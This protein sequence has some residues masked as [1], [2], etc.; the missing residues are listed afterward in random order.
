MGFEG[1]FPL[2]G[3]LRVGEIAPR[4]RTTARRGSRLAAR[5]K[6]LTPRPMEAAMQKLILS[7]PRFLVTGLMLVVGTA[8]APLTPTSDLLP[9]TAWGQDPETAAVPGQELDTHHLEL[10]GGTDSPE[11][12]RCPQI[13]VAIPASA[14]VAPAAIG[15]AGCWRALILAGRAFLECIE[16][17]AAIAD[18][19]VVNV[20]LCLNC[21]WNKIKDEPD[22]RECWEQIRDWVARRL[23]TDPGGPGPG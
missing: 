8:V 22:V 2:I 15:S 16:C 17:A 4:G 11:L 23:G 13:G 21:I 6:K 19:S 9:V 10:T 14:E 3:G 12:Q 1:V 5:G 7:T 20:G 18:P